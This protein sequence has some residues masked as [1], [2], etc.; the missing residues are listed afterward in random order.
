M[1]PS[2][3]LLNERAPSSCLEDNRPGEVESVR[4]RIRRV[5]RGETYVLKQLLKVPSMLPADIN[6]P[7][8]HL[9]AQAG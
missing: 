4:L 1:C 5:Q 9:T 3:V 8:T 6:A 2:A 7:E